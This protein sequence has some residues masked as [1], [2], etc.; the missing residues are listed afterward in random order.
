MLRIMLISTPLISV[1][2]LA[3]V[4]FQS[5]GKAFPAMIL[6]IGRQGVIFVPTVLI[7]RRLFGYS[8]VIWSQ[9]C[10]D[11]ITFILA[12]ILFKITFKELF[13]HDN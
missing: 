5:A 4:M 3:T 11:V 9:T 6:S 1:I 13:T 12:M 8:G 2:L 7:L 10:A